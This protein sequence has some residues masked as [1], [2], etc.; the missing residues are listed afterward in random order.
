VI[1]R[2]LTP[3]NIML[4]DDG[5]VLVLD[6]DFA[7]ALE[8]SLAGPDSM[9]RLPRSIHGEQSEDGHIMGTPS[10]M[11]PEQALGDI[12]RHGPASD[13]YALGATLY[14]LLSGRPPYTGGVVTIVSILRQMHIARPAPLC[15]TD[16]APG[17]VAICERAMAQEP[18]LRY[19]DAGALAAAMRAFLACS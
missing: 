13:V 15:A 11:P 1:H 5:S 8:G 18:G 2:N 4:G 19:A 10:Y 9:R 17:L 12:R 3:D 7:L 6:W 16:A 14:H